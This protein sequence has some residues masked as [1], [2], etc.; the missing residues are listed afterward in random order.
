M[1]RSSAL[2]A[3]CYNG[4]CQ[5]TPS[6]SNYRAISPDKAPFYGKQ[7]PGEQ[8]EP[9]RCVWTVGGSS[10]PG[11]RARPLEAQHAREE[12]LT[13]AELRKLRSRKSEDFWN[14][15]AT[16]PANSTRDRAI[17]QENL[18]LLWGVRSAQEHKLSGSL[19][20][21]NRPPAVVVTEIVVTTREEAKA[22]GGATG[23]FSGA[24][25]P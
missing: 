4:G 6:P 2:P 17:A 22:V 21:D 8:P 10:I 3:C 16:D 7:A 9:R 13:P 5:R 1:R 20:G 14:D 11:S 19:S 18:D 12:G 25:V 23:I 24:Q 15:M